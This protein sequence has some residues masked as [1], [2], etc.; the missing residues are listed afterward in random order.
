[1]ITPEAI[2]FMATHGRGLICLAMTGERLDQLVFAQMAPDNSAL[3]GTAFR[4]SIDAKGHGVTTGI[5]A[6]DRAQTMRAAI[7][8][9]R[10]ARY[11]PER[12]VLASG[13]TRATFRELHDRV[14]RMAAALSRHGFGAGDRLA[15]L[16]PNAL[17]YLELVYAC[18]W[19]GVMAVPLNIRLS[20]IEIDRV[21]ADASP[22][23]LIRHSSLPV[24]TVPLD[25]R[26]DSYP[27]AL[28]NPE[29]I[30][31]LVYTS[32]TTCRPKGGVLT[33]ADILAN[34]YNLDGLFHTR[35]VGY[36]DHVAA[37]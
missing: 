12:T 28:Y 31:A 30:L 13:G 22:R 37:V 21:F 24:P 17:E 35:D 3:G 10:A 25:V 8:L 15:I 7:S 32:G 19:L 20:A 11:S 29:A 23:G 34:V 18:R 2:N 14:A 1:M 5:S 36:Q 33:H 27:D 9:G 26:S 16:L 6:H 4:V